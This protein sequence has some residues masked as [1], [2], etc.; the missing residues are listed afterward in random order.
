[1]RGS[2]RYAYCVVI[3][4][5]D[6]GRSHRAAYGV[7]FGRGYGFETKNR[8][9]GPRGTT[10]GRLILVHKLLLVWGWFVAC[11]VAIRFAPVDWGG[12]IRSFP[13]PHPLTPSPFS[14]QIIQ[15][16]GRGRPEPPGWRRYLWLMLVDGL[17]TSYPV[18][19]S[20]LGRSGLSSTSRTYPA[21]RPSG[22]I[23]LAWFPWR[24]DRD[25]RT[26]R[27]TGWRFCRGI[28]AR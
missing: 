9:G 12:P 11:S 26:D 3:I 15:N 27:H 22:P 17:S 4:R 19:P 13:E 16:Q 23:G 14:A 28:P 24:F 21:R 25:L 5:P 1:M 20:G 8:R 18:R 6:G 10:I 2:R 7:A